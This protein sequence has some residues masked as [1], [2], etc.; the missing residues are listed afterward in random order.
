MKDNRLKTPVPIS[1][2]A[3]KL[4][5]TWIDCVGSSRTWSFVSLSSFSTWSYHV[6]AIAL[7]SV[8]IVA[9]RIVSLSHPSYFCIHNNFNVEKRIAREASWPGSFSSCFM[10][11]PHPV[12]VLLTT[13]NIY[14]SN[15]LWRCFPYKTV[16]KVP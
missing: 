5:S 16:M 1:I 2:K 13:E 10:W 12:L 4:Y 6:S 8:F 3:W 15:F 14:R 9:W 11:Y 7:T